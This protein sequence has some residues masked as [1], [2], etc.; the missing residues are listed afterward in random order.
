MC[1]EEASKRHINPYKVYL[2]KVG[3]YIRCA[4][5]LQTMQ[6]SMLLKL[7]KRVALSCTASLV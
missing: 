1:I 7:P 3:M 6:L 4:T 5:F 2:K